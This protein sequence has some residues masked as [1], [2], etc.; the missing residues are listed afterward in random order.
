MVLAEFR[1]ILN[2]CRNL[3]LAWFARGAINHRTHQS[4]ETRLFGVCFFISSQ[5]V[6]DT[7]LAMFTYLSICFIG[8]LEIDA[9]I[10]ANKLLNV[11]RY[12]HHNPIIG[13]FELNALQLKINEIL[14]QHL[15]I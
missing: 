2:T 3:F 8:P 12:R 14:V 13:S 6:I 10:L 4:D 7:A 1:E 9:G 5:A 11:D 15:V